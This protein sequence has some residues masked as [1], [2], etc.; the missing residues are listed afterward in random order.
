MYLLDKGKKKLNS[1]RKETLRNTIIT[2]HI[3]IH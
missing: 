3:L 1:K 2:Q